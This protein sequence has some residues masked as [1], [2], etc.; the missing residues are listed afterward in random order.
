MNAHE[1]SR[2]AARK[3]LAFA[4]AYFALQTILRV[5]TTRSVELDEAE[6]LVMA[7]EFRWGYGVQPPLYTWVQSLFFGVFGVNILALALLKNFILFGSCFFT[8]RAVREMTADVRSAAIASSSLFL[9]PQFAWE[10]QRDQTHSVLAVMIGVALLCTLIRLTKNR[11]ALGYA[12]FGLLGALGCMTK[13]NFAVFLVALPLAVLSLKRFRG[14]V[15]DRRAWLAASVFALSGL[16]HIVW[17]RRHPADWLARANEVHEH[18]ATLWQ[19]CVAS[20]AGLIVAIVAFSGLAAL[21]FGI[22]FF[23][24]AVVTEETETAKN[25]RRLVG[26]ILLVAVLI[27]IALAA[28]F[29]AHFKDRWMQPVLFITPIVLT[30]WFFRRLDARRTKLLL[31]VNAFIA[32]A[33]LIALAATPV[34]AAA[35]GHHRYL[36]LDYADLAAQLQQHGFSRGVIVSESRKT[37]GNLKLSLPDSLMLAP[38][39]PVFQTPANGSC[40]LVW[41]TLP[42]AGLFAP[43]ALTNLVWKACGVDFSG[44]TP[45]GVE[46]PLEHCRGRTT[47]YAFIIITNA[48]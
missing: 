48:H 31:A 30:L 1:S 20:F 3:F 36:S 26:R 9:L 46:I 41:G 47:R 10:S 21:V 14:V 8:F 42:A 19:A 23:R 37:G 22:V 27:C 17:M 24:V 16:P 15:S 40:A 4:F 5:L 34:W 45:T 7:Q 6:Q 43:P 33:V 28:G 25:F 11:S 29:Q 38:E 12:L 35:T 13:Y 18:A 39:T 2:L 32:A 44:R